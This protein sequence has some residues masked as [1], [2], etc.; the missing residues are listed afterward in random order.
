[1]MASQRQ[2]RSTFDSANT[3]YNIDRILA[4]LETPK[5]YVELSELLHLTDRSIRRYIT[6][7]RAKP[8]QRVYVCKHPIVAGRYVLLF[9]LGKKRDAIRTVQ[10]EYE[11]NANYRARVKASPERS[12]F[13]HRYEAA[14]WAVRKA[15]RAPSGWAAA[16]GVC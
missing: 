4:T 5:T 6:H 16:L 8:N 14:R 7:L 15:K 1:M 10:T 13:R 3:I 2:G 12:E 11:R 9:A